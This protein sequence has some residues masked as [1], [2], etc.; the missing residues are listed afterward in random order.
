MTARPMVRRDRM[1]CVVAVPNEMERDRSPRVPAIASIVH[2]GACPLTSVTTRNVLAA[3]VPIAL[4][5]GAVVAGGLA[6]RKF[7]SGAKRVRL[8][9]GV[10]YRTRIMDVCTGA[11]DERAIGSSRG[12]VWNCSP[13]ILTTNGTLPPNT[14][15]RRA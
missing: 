8:E 15:A 12:I 9:K 1:A 13:V 7:C 10:S 2:L 5:L 6:D 3:F 4:A 11:P 14:A